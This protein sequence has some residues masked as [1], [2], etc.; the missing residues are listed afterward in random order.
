M[1]G[2]RGGVD[3][4]GWASHGDA[5][6]WRM[7]EDGGPGDGFSGR[8]NLP[9]GVSGIYWVAPPPA[10]PPYPAIVDPPAVAKVCGLDLGC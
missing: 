1:I 5:P 10:S 9:S 8:T 6:G 4:M 7:G 2:G 3:G